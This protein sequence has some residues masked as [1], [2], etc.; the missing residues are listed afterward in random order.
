[1]Y[2]ADA[3][4][5]HQRDETNYPDHPEE[6]PSDN[7]DRAQWEQQPREDKRVEGNLEG[8]ES[9]YS[10]PEYVSESE[11]DDGRY[12]AEQAAIPP[13]ESARASESRGAKLSR[14]PS[15]SAASGR[16]TPDARQGG[17]PTTTAA[18]MHPVDISQL[19][20]HE[21]PRNSSVATSS[22]AG[23]AGS[24]YSDLQWDEVAQ[25]M[26][27]GHRAP[28]LAP[29]EPTATT[30]SSHA[31]N[32]VYGD[33]NTSLIRGNN[34]KEDGNFW[35]ISSSSDSND[36][37]ESEPTHWIGAETRNSYSA[38]A[39]A[40]RSPAAIASPTRTE[41]LGNFASPLMRHRTRPPGAPIQSPNTGS[42]M[43]GNG[44]AQSPATAGRMTSGAA[45]TPTSATRKVLAR[46]S[47][48]PKVKV[49]IQSRAA[50]TEEAQLAA[51]ATKIAARNEVDDYI[52]SLK[53][54]IK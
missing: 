22:D 9:D 18:G 46:P 11:N 44:G 26:R 5:E 2:S 37:R 16:L 17:E 20:S 10:R 39:T 42:Y 19:R 4:E 53:R 30:S 12:A 23:Y 7:Q 6:Q 36:L 32:R 52:A 29:M 25:V 35:D 38:G 50:L 48:T 28:L 24:R 49:P 31:G 27:V 51:L 3:P 8:E 41:S 1:V 45:G 13:Q 40:T 43:V 47:S 33:G 15:N 54:T 34:A 14:Q 21:M